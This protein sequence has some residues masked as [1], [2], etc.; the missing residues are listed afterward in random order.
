[1]DK[2]TIMEKIEARV[3][4][5]THKDYKI[6][7][8]GVTDDPDTRKSKHKSD[9]KNVDFW[10]QWKADSEDD[11]RNIESY[12]LEK[13]GMKGGSGGPGSADYVYIF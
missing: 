13:K 3:M 1:M 12:Y 8:I 4:S 9:G 7:T 2:K 6:W 11:A 10:N 5:E